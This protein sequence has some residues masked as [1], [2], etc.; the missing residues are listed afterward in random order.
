MPWT[1]AVSGAAIRVG[2]KALLDE[3]WIKRTRKR[4][5]ANRTAFEKM[6]IQADFSVVGKTDLFLLVQIE[7]A[8][9]LYKHLA[10]GFIL[11]RPFPGREDWLRLGIP[12]KKP[13]LNRVAKTLV[14]FNK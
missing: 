8:I 7:N 2:T 14:G 11:T 3:S 10:S 4:L 13:A 5:T 9:E 12:G 1:L 6:L